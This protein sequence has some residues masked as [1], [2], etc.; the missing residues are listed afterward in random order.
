MKVCARGGCT[1]QVIV[2]VNT[3]CSRHCR[4]LAMG[5]KVTDRVWSRI[6]LRD[7]DLEPSGGFTEADLRM[8]IERYRLTGQMTPYRPAVVASPSNNV[9][10]RRIR[11]RQLELI[12]EALTASRPPL[13]KVV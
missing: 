2:E 6:H 11:D 7:V 5:L 4:H 10:H 9:Q 3:Y 12:T 13:R 1:A 8:L